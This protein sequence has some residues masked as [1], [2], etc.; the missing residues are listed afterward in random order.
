MN[1]IVPPLSRPPQ[2]D[3]AFAFPRGADPALIS[4]VNAALVALKEAGE[5]IKGG[6]LGG[7]ARCG[8]MGS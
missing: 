8:R 4:A 3:Q 5:K 1:T 2:Y 7:R 6:G